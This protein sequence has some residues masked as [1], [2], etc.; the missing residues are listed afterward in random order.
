M[1]H[2]LVPTDFSTNAYNALFYASR[3]FSYEPLKITLV[4]SFEEELR[5]QLSVSKRDNRDEL[6]G[7]IK[8]QIEDRLEALRHQ[9]IRDTE[10]YDVEVFCTETASPLH[11]SID[12][13]INI[14]EADYLIMGTKGAS[15]LK[16]VF[17][18]SQTVSIMKKALKIPMMV[19]PEQSDFQAPNKVTYATDFKEDYSDQVVPLLK[20]LYNAY[21]FQVQLVHVYTQETP[22]E[23]VQQH[24]RELKTAL[25]F[26]THSTH[27]VASKEPKNK[28]IAAFLRQH[29]S[30]LL[31][32]NYHKHGF[33]KTLLN[34][35]VVERVSF[36][37]T[38]PLML[39]PA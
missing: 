2:I 39:L 6:Y 4:H 23:E 5:R 14:T 15:G 24:Y 35:S 28:V 1:P 11:S 21:P 17:I 10:D 19:I 30:S 29:S 22:E 7:E 16:A 20:E 36:D 37:L 13:L 26:L 34:R 25:D 27:W 8:E 31:L 33:L 3:F 38:V 18:G 9:I 12:H 32:M